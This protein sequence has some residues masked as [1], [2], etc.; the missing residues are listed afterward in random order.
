MFF[1]H[2]TNFAKWRKCE[3]FVSFL[4]CVIILRFKKFFFIE[5]NLEYCLCV[6]KVR[7]LD[8]GENYRILYGNI[9]MYIN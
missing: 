1:S 9:I 8:H 3:H 6:F 4:I 5:N 7:K 2:V